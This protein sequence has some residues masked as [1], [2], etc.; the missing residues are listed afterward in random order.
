[1]NPIVKTQVEDFAARNSVQSFSVSDQFEIYS[2]YAIINGELKE[3]VD[4]FSI[5]LKGS[6]FGVDGAC[7]IVQGQ[8]CE[9]SDV[10]S[11]V[12]STK[13]REDVDF[14]FIQSKTSE[15]ADYGD[16]S[17]FLDSVFQFFDGGMEG[18]SDQLDDLITV[19]EDVFRLSLKRNPSLKCYFATT[20]SGGISSRIESLINERKE[21]LKGLSLFREVNIELIGASN[22]QTSYRSATNSITE[23]IDFPKN[24]L[25][26]DHECVQE[27]FIGYIDASQ[28][29]RLVTGAGNSERINRTVFFDNVRDF[30]PN[31]KINKSILQELKSGDREAFGYRNNGITI[32]A[33]DV[34]RIRD[35]FTLENYQIVN[36]CQTSNLLFHQRESLQG[37]FVPLRL[38]G[39]SDPDF[40]ATII[41]GTNKQNEVN[42]EQFLA[43]KPFMK[44]LEEYFRGRPQAEQL[45]LERRE[46]QYR[47]DS[48]ERTRILKPRDA[49]KS[50]GAFMLRQPHRSARDYRAILKDFEGKIFEEGH[51]IRIYH[52]GCFAGYRYDFLVRNQKIERSRSIH[53]FYTLYALGIMF[54][55][56]KD[57]LGLKKIVREEVSKKVVEMVLDEER[58]RGF[59]VEVSEL[60]E[61]IVQNLKIDTREQLRDTLRTESFLNSFTKQFLDGRSGD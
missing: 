10:L 4:P 20:G 58:F 44:D 30:N 31:S 38:I 42:E 5:H 52:C 53:K 33:Q 17:K 40:V 37:V 49:M 25:L 15:K 36:G 14:V 18:E 45:F 39:S 32:V 3:T 41:V 12:V 51:D 11:S 21:K 59:C 7:V 56:Q 28:I 13:G 46:N 2:I 9:N 8:A 43:L 48:I 26:P 35:E 57:L 27:A 6:E 23:K 16:I 19:K 54:G 61:E 55:G 47:G 24:I 60:C 34:Q 50:V 22:L 1:M 29:V